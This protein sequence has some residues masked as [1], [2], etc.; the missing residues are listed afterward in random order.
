M[1]INTYDD[2]ISK[3][4][5]PNVAPA[6]KRLNTLRE[7]IQMGFSVI[8][9][10]NPIIP[11]VTDGENLRNLL[12]KMSEI[13]VKKVTIEFLEIPKAQY[14]FFD[15]MMKRNNRAGALFKDLYNLYYNNAYFPSPNYIIETLAFIIKWA[16]EY[17]VQVSF[18]RDT[19]LKQKTCSILQDISKFKE[20]IF[21]FFNRLDKNFVTT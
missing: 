19:F 18:C 1:S 14:N 11:M 17:N 6:S 20:R 9:R 5:E 15:F 2:K 12:L 21:D 8:P 7:A 10:V 3:E 4:F 16:K 13:G